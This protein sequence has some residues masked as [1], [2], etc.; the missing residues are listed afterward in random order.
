MAELVLREETTSTASEDFKSNRIYG[1]RYVDKTPLLA[2]LLDRKHETTF[3]LRPRRFGKTLTLSMIRYF[4]EDTGDPELNEENRSLFRGLK[5]MEM[6]E[7]YTGRMTSFPVVQLTF[8]TDIGV[9][10]KDAFETLTGSIQELYNNKQY[11]LDSKKL[12]TEEKCY[13]QRI[14]REKDENGKKVTRADYK[15]ALK[16]MTVFLR[17][18]SGKRAVVLIDEYDVPLEKA[19]QNGY[20][21]EMVGLIGPML[22]NVLKTNSENLQFAVVTGC[23]RIAKEGIYTGLNNPEINTVTSVR[24]GDVIG[25]TEAEVQK[26]LADSGVPESFPDAKEWYDGYRFGNAVIYNPWSVIKFI[27]D[28]VVEPQCCPR[29]YWAGTS[30]NSIVRELADHADDETRAR[31]EKL[32][33]G[34]EITFALK[35]DIVYDDLFR[36]PDNVFNVMLSAGYLT[37]VSM[38]EKLGRTEIRAR[39]PNREVRQI[40]AGKFAEWFRE[41]I[42]AFDIREL[43]RMMEQGNTERM[44]EILTDCFLS[45]MSYFDTQEAFYHG[46]M[47]ALMQL[48]REYLCRSNR[49]SGSGRFDMVCKQQTRWKLAFVLEFKVSKTPGELAS[50]AKQAANQIEERDYIAD[51]QAEGYEKI[52]TYGFAFC[53]KRCRVIQGKTWEG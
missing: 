7:K 48:N 41:S 13:F 27:E 2:P 38:E 51:L 18:D 11:L 25:F 32:V 4:V 49:E 43:Y 5:I 42:A 45:S 20:Y 21:K 53:E 24:N 14:L 29:P 34:E 12:T 39:I 8:Q 1:I 3:F 16:M 19:Y 52:M 6:G 31:A 26:L 50:D 22:Q 44:E 35:D 9:D 10:F 36:E 37:A 15:K 23:L 28:R 46:V 47:L 17:K 33:Q 40:Y 30:S